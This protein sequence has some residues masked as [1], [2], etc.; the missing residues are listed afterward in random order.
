[1]SK[2][3]LD[4]DGG[5]PI[6]DP[7]FIQSPIT[8]PLSFPSFHLLIASSSS[9]LSHIRYR[10]SLRSHLANTPLRGDTLQSLMCPLKAR[11]KDLSLE[12]KLHEHNANDADASC[13][14]IPD[15][16]FC[17]AMQEHVLPSA[18]LLAEMPAQA[19]SSSCRGPEH[20]A[21]I[22]SAAF[23]AHPEDRRPHHAAEEQQRQKVPCQWHTTVCQGRAQPCHRCRNCNRRPRKRWTAFFHCQVDFGAI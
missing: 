11:P 23:S 16:E 8:G 2:S 18:D 20:S 4:P 21:A 7:N 10:S 1:M 17:F 9:C 14:C 19:H 13:D 15:S 3:D 5:I 6:C 22:R 12:C